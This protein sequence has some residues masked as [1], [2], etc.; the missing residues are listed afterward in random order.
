MEVQTAQHAD[1]EASIDM[2]YCI[3]AVSAVT[4]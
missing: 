1:L 2:T 3:D 4:Q